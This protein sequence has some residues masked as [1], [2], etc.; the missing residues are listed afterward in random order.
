MKGKILLLLALPV[1]GYVGAKLYLHIQV[2]KTIDSIVAQVA[3]F[4]DVSYESVTS[5]FDGRI[6]VSNVKI[7]PRFIDDEVRIQEVSFKLPSMK[8]LLDLETRVQNQDPPEELSIRVHNVA[9]STRGNLVQAWEDQMFA[10]DSQARLTALDNCVTRSNLPTQMYLLDYE[11]IRGSFEVGYYYDSNRGHF[12]VHG[13]VGQL[14]AYEFSGELAVV[15]ASF[16]SF[17]MMTALSNPQI[18]RASLEITDKGYFERVFDYC[19]TDSALSRQDVIALLTAELLT[20]FDDLP[21]KPDQPLVD[22]YT[23][24]IAEGTKLTITADP[25]EPQQLQYLSLYAPEDV[26][27]LLNIRTQVN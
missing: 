8:Y 18:A 21:M 26:P 5:T 23:R 7:R 1:I 24:F 3:P 16:N 9:V 19:A 27:A 22:A 25:L 10:D 2:G 20:M 15:M 17:A 14:E 11:E 6:G 13:T 12:V 4:A